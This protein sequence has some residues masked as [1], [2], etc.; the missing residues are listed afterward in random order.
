MPAFS[1]D[2]Q[3]RL[4]EAGADGW[5][6][7]VAANRY[8]LFGLVALSQLVASIQFASVAVSLP[9]IIDDLNA[10]LR[11]VGWI[12]SISTLAQA[13][14]MPIAGKLS[15][16]LGR[17]TVFVGGV[18]LFAAASLA[19]ALSPNVYFLIASRTIQGLAGGALL[20]SAYGIVSDAFPDRRSQMLGMMSAIF[21]IGAIVGPNVGGVLVDAFSWRWTFAINLPIAVPVLIAAIIMMPRDGQRERTGSTDFVGAGLLTM[22]IASLIYALT[23]LSQEE[24]SPNLLIVVTSFAV[25]AGSTYF[26]IRRE[27]SVADPILEPRLVAQGEFLWMNTLNF[28]Y[29]VSIF[30]ILSFLPLYVEEA[31]GMS[32]SET[33][34]LMTPRAVLMIFV[35]AAA[36][37]LITRTG[38]RRPIA[39]GLLI[40]AAAMA[41]LSLGLEGVAVAGV[42]VSNFVYLAAVIALCGLGLAIAGPSANNAAIEL[43]PEKAAAITG[44]RGMFRFIGG[45]VGFAVVVLVTSR[46]PSTAEGLE[47]SF[48]GLAIIT[49]LTTLLVR[50][51]PD[52]PTVIA[53]GGERVDAA[54]RAG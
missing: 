43:A 13:V 3:S 15:D 47:L 37:L 12:V 51:I 28:F 36:A 32:A 16:E 24:V 54:Q 46:A 19:C 27:L 17:K 9:N 11:W 7:H 23:E 52:R 6:T 2:P 18:G 25:S 48:V 49:A 45:A 39:A 22:A 1:L 40:M 26:F 4:C 33:G 38:Y 41:I 35:S 21:P 53:A 30:G 44:M 29:G 14:A 10:P 34:L 20:P 5:S 31:Y 42:G 8:L 50:G